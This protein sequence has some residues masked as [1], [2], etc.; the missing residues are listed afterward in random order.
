MNGIRKSL[1]RF[2]FPDD[3][4]KNPWLSLLMTAYALIDE[5]VS[6]AIAREEKK[7]GVRPAC[8]LGCDVCCR[9]HR[10]IPCYPIELVG[11][12]WLVIEKMEQ[13]HRGIVKQQLLGHRKGNPCPFLIDRACAVHLVRPTACR[14]FTV[15]TTECTEG[16]DP[17]YSRRQDVMTPITEYVDAALDV[18]LPF[19]GITGKDARKQAV[20]GRLINARI[21]VL[22]EWP[23][24]ELALRM[25]DFDFSRQ[26]S[27]R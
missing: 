23:W 10:D 27:G 5:G 22:Q 24:S 2:S 26:A 17:F 15:F 20:Q 11:I 4:K 18:T 16:E 7:R 1:K 3:E 13:P 8:R 25:D 9:A 12:S 21:Q 19:Y 6:I 14:Q